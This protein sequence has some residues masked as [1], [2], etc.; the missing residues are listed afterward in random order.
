MKQEVKNDID[1]TAFEKYLSENEVRFIYELLP[2]PWYKR[3]FRKLFKKKD[4]WPK[5]LSVK[6]ICFN[7][8]FIDI[9]DK[10]VF[11]IISISK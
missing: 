7:G 10:D 6:Q 3:L 5:G 2:L 8:E 1:S 9:S 4:S 11:K